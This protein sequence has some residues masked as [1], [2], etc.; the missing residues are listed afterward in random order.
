MIP[1]NN[2]AAAPRF[3]PHAPVV[4]PGMLWLYRVARVCVGVAVVLLA[5]FFMFPLFWMVTTSVKPIAEVMMTPPAWL[6]T[7]W[8]WDN[9]REATRIIPFWTYT[10]NTVRVCLLYVCGVV[11]S[12]ALVGYG[13]ACLTWPGRDRF[14]AITL[15]TMMIPFPVLMVPLFAIFLKLGWIGTLMP[16]WVPAFFGTAYN[17]FLM[18]QFLMMVP[19]ELAEAARIDGCGEFRVFWQVVLPQVRTPLMIVA[20]FAF[21]YAWNDFFGPLV[22]LTDKEL[23]TLSLGLQD[24]HAGMGDAPTNLLMAAATLMILPVLLL[25]FLFQRAFLQGVSL[26]HVMH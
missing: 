9:Y 7:E 6:P 22:F 10:W 2:G 26:R 5:L 23:F 8:K 15:A 16:L 14:F 25:F 18:R 11:L 21:L 13:F 20:L 17:I 4:W 24:Y 19:A 12:S 3:D 1:R